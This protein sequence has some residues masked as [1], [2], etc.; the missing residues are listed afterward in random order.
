MRY[1]ETGRLEDRILRQEKI[2]FWNMGKGEQIY[3]ISE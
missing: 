2:G 1:S 3:E